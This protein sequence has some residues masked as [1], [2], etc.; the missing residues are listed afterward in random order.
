MISS[1][2]RILKRHLDFLPRVPRAC[3]TQHSE[4]T[5]APSQDRLTLAMSLSAF[6]S[7][8][9]L[10]ICLQ[11]PHRGGIYYNIQKLKC[12]WGWRNGTVV[13]SVCAA[14]PDDWKT[15]PRTHTGWLTTVCNSSSQGCNTFPWPPEAP[16]YM[17]TH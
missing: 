8:S 11:L 3:T 12:S 9:P 16:T 2:T 4:E 13:Q 17:H 1:R 10:G 6:I 7:Q 15:I 14:L 5:K